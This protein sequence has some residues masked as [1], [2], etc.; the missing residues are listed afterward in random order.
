MMWKIKTEEEE[1][2]KENDRQSRDM[3]AL[4]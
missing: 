2:E 1:E 3:C 4:L